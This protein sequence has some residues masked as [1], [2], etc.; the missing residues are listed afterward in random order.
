MPAQFD[1]IFANIA[2]LFKKNVKSFGVIWGN[3]KFVTSEPIW[4]SK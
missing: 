4:K 2:Y 3:N 1:Y